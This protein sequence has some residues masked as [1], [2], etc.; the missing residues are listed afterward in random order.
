[1]KDID[2]NGLLVA[3][4]E[5]NDAEAVQT[6]LAMKANPN[7]ATISDD[8]PLTIAIKNGKAKI[9]EMLLNAGAD[10]FYKHQCLAYA[11]LYASPAMVDLIATRCPNLVN[12]PVDN[13][14][15]ITPLHC[16]VSRMSS[17]YYRAL[18]P[19]F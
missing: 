19:K 16:A 7:V 17:F 11:C 18:T 13:T 4:A 12:Q 15:C 8:T 2:E 5:N 6:L 9:V 3:A 10:P 14:R 1:V